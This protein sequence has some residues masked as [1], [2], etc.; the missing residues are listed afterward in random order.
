MTHDCSSEI[1]GAASSPVHGLCSGPESYTGILCSNGFL[2]KHNKAIIEL[3]KGQN[4]TTNHVTTPKLYASDQ[5]FL[6]NNN[7]SNVQANISQSKEVCFSKNDEKLLSVVSLQKQ[8]KD[9]LMSAEESRHKQE[10][11]PTNPALPE[12]RKSSVSASPCPKVLAK[13]M[14]SN[15]K[16]CMLKINSSSG[17]GLLDFNKKYEY[18]PILQASVETF[19]MSQNNPKQSGTRK[20]L[21]S[22]MISHGCGKVVMEKIIMKMRLQLIIDANLVN[23]AGEHPM[24]SSMETFALFIDGQVASPSDLPEA[25]HN[26][27]A[28]VLANGLSPQCVKSPIAQQVSELHCPYKTSKMKTFYG[29]SCRI[30]VSSGIYNHSPADQGVPMSSSPEDCSSPL[31]AGHQQHCSPV[32][33]KKD[34]IQENISSTSFSSSLREDHISKIPKTTDRTMFVPNEFYQPCWEDFPYQHSLDGHQKSKF[35]HLFQG[36]QQDVIKLKCLLVTRKESYATLRDIELYG[37]HVFVHFTKLD[38]LLAFPQLP[39]LCASPSIRFGVYGSLSNVLEGKVRVVLT[40]MRTLLLLH[41]AALL[42]PNTGDVLKAVMRSARHHTTLV[43]ANTLRMCASLLLQRPRTPTEEKYRQVLKQNLT[44]VMKCVEAG[45]GHILG[46]NQE[47]VCANLS[48]ASPPSE[49]LMCLRFVH[50]CLNFAHRYTA[51]LIGEGL[52]ETCSHQ[53]SLYRLSAAREVLQ[54]FSME[55]P[56]ARNG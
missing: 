3:E 50:R 27:G 31:E 23:Y 46:G 49:Y 42:D 2:V 48:P 24:S 26:P 20:S 53:L 6:M 12:M 18:L 38:Q 10:I 22:K 25:L 21:F 35:I 40:D 1:T 36:K 5:P 8:V 28:S 15:I 7:C 32:S 16:Y 39:K 30:M 14:I 56:C 43:P 51:V 54:D 44:L 45:A 13:R 47:S 34:P 52:E 41:H 17:S 33:L 37:G 11:D 29:A 4:P 19:F 55:A 9:D